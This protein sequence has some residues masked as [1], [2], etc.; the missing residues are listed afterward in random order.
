ME[1]IVGIGG[2][3]V[4]GNPGDVIKTFALSTCVGLVYYSRLR[5]VMGMSHVQLPT[6]QSQDAAGQPSRYGDLAPA[7]L[8][9]EMQR[10]FGVM[11][12]EIVVSLYGGIDSR[13]S[14][15]FRIG[16]KNL[17]SVKKGLSA[18]GLSYSSA[19][20]GGNNSRTL[21]AYVDGGVVEVISRPMF[22]AGR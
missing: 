1:Y 6:A 11:R 20:T 15:F 22:R 7:H 12:G 2:F 13:P 21:Y 10:A 5:R 3:A 17:E 9:R 8:L 18:L 16:E 4:A 14:D 19:D